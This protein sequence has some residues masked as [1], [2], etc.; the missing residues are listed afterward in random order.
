M[1]PNLE[2]R[3][4]NEQVK[5]KT[6]PKG[7]ERREQILRTATEV[8]SMHSFH[9]SS[10]R[11]LPRAAEVCEAMI[12]RHYPTKEAL[13]DAILER[14]FERSRYLYFPIQAAKAGRDREVLETI[15]GNYLREQRTDNSFMR[16]LLFSALEDHELARKFVEKLLQDYFLFLESYFEKRMKDGVLK[17]MDPQVV[18]RLLIAMVHFFALL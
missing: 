6:R 12:Y 8:L 9:G 11:Q 3:I 14:K 18:A 10:M 1:N 2:G 7:N 17:T 4:V 15:V 13:Y 5:E 16:M